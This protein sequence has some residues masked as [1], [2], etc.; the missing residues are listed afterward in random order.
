MTQTDGPAITETADILLI[1]DD[2]QWARATARLLEHNVGAFQV[3]TAHTLGEGEMR[4][5]EHEFDCVVCDYQLGDGTGLALLELV[6]EDDQSVPFILV[7]GRGDEQVASKATRK[8]ITEYIIK[9]HDDSEAELLTTRVANA[10]ESYRTA[11]ALKRERRSKN[12][13]VTLLTATIDE[14]TL[15]QEFC[16]LLVGEY[17]YACAWIGS[18][19][20]RS[21]LVSLAAI[22]TDS[23]IEEVLH[24]PTAE[25]VGDPVV[26]AFERDE[27]VVKTSD[28]NWRALAEAYG[29]D[30]GVAIPIRHE[31]VRFGVLGVYAA[32]RAQVT[33]EQLTVLNEFAE[34]VGYA[35]HT[36]EWKRTLVSDR[37]ITVGVEIADEAVALVAFER[38]LPDGVS[39][40]VPSVLQR[41][42]GTTVY[43]ANIDG[44]PT[45]AVETA[46]KAGEGVTLVE[47]RTQGNGSVQ[48]VLAVTARTPEAVLAT[49][50]ATVERTVVERGIARITVRA[51]SHEAVTSLNDAIESVYQ[52]GAVTSIRRSTRTPHTNTVA[53]TLEPLTEKQADALRH[54]YYEGFFEHP[55]DVT[56]T[57]LA[58]QF[59]I[60]RQTLTH[61]LRAAERKVFEQV[62]ENESR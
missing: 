46:A 48:C 29:F 21:G 13:M 35:L 53:Q 42:D 30:A 14:S 31:G 24:N 49:Q 58:K 26:A 47:E 19:T 32:D 10:I 52:K 3:T 39:I 43:L 41:E 59:G 23:F 28:E 20:E 61:H 34:T 25:V 1:D 15:C 62:F 33:D 55:R 44:V 45:T 56:A 6:R 40:T 11:Q 4:Y 5:G 8:G 22:G 9:E 17:G 37:P 51:P 12:T 27:P 60:T 50:G 2:E 16:R 36:A 18:E 38:A 57:E 54:A 7:T